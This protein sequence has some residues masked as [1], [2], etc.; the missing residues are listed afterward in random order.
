MEQNA[1]R[2]GESTVPPPTLPQP[3]R[4]LGTLKIQEPC[5]KNQCCDRD[6]WLGQGQGDV[7]GYQTGKTCM[8]LFLLWN[9]EEM[10]RGARVLQ[11]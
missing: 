11:S 7:T 4:F 10:F 8:N 9:L 2:I 5:A 3:L 6:L 1:H